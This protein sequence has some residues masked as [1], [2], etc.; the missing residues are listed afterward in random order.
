MLL[1]YADEL[2]RKKFT[3]VKNKVLNSGKRIRDR[4]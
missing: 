4:I 1:K 2:A 3:V